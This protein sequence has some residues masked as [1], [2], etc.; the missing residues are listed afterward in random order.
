MS[1]KTFGFI[2][3]CI[4][5]RYFMYAGTFTASMKNTNFKSIYMQNKQRHPQ[6]NASASLLQ[7]PKPPVLPHIFLSAYAVT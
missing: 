4:H 1:P 5:F 6:Q 7:Q 2:K 3:N